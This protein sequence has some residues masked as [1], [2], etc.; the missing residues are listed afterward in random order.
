M[1]LWDKCDAEGFDSTKKNLQG[2]YLKRDVIWVKNLPRNEIWD[3]RQRNVPSLVILLI[4]FFKFLAF[5]D[6]SQFH[7]L[8][9]DSIMRFINFLCV[10]VYE[11]KIARNH[12]I[13]S[14]L[15]NS[16]HSLNNN[17]RIR[18]RMKYMSERRRKYSL[19]AR[20]TQE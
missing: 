9:S 3:I 11:N 13:S 15:R 16:K 12:K 4:Y 2:V 8:I 10:H 18:F 5:A 20:E 1:Y 17:K 6:I 14:L 7:M 19:R